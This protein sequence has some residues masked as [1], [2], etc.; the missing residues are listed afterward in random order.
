MKKAI[1]LLPLLATLLC[2]PAIAAYNLSGK[3][4]DASNSTALSGVRVVL[5]GQKA[6]VNTDAAGAY[7]LKNGTVIS[8][9]VAVSS[10]SFSSSS[11]LKLSSSNTAIRSNGIRLEQGVLNLSEFRGQQVS[12]SIFNASGRRFDL[13]NG[14]ADASQ[15]D[16]RQFTQ[17]LPMGAYT[18]VVRASSG[19]YSTRVASVGGFMVNATPQRSSVAIPDTLMFIKTGYDSKKLAVADIMQGA[20]S[21]ISLSKGKFVRMGYIDV[22]NDALL[23]KVIWDN[24]THVGV[25]S[26]NPTEAGEIYRLKDSK[27]STSA[28]WWPAGSPNPSVIRTK[29]YPIFKS[30]GIKTLLVVGGAGYATKIAKVC[31]TATARTEMVK[32][33]AELV[34][35]TAVDEY[36]SYASAPFDGV[37]MDWESP[38]GT[39]GAQCFTTLMKEL[40]DAMPDKLVTAAVMPANTGYFAATVVQ[41]YVDWFGLMTYDL[42]LD[43]GRYDHSPYGLSIGYMSKWVNDGVKAD[44]LLMGIATYG[45]NNTTGS[46]PWVSAQADLATN[47]KYFCS[48]DST[49]A[50]AKYIGANN[51]KGVI[52]WRVVDDNYGFTNAYSTII[53]SEF[54]LQG[55]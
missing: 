2:G 45:D 54:K 6:W 5:L 4:V 38:V 28:I 43:V 7:S 14:L 47:Q 9:S 55:R 3:V 17:Q 41:D 12:I 20:V 1:K 51:H 15:I 53:D 11:S 16:M 36:G 48:V 32:Q 49:K 30:K 46:M 39:K 25:F 19:V 42:G 37:D 10:S 52:Y 50:K 35:G 34:N 13:W 21:Q 8:S 40:R 24:Y 22:Q 27:V 26:V 44:K 18:L 23:S 33:I 29:Y 31:T